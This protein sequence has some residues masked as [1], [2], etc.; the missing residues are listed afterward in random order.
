MIF[1]F[2]NISYFSL[3]TVIPAA[4][5]QNLFYSVNRPNYLN[6]GTIGYVTGHELSHAFDNYVIHFS[7]S[8]Y[9]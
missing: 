7:N 8:I 6:F 5:L 1:Y 9:K 3:I 2:L 4:I